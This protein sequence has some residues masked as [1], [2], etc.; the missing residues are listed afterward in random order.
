MKQNLNRGIELGIYRDDL[1]IEFISRIYFTGL[2]GI[3][4]TD[5]FPNNV[6]APKVLTELYLEYHLR[7]IVTPKGL[8]TLNRILAEDKIIF[9]K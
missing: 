1:D 5:I 8:E 6:F 9:K 3:K 7:S 4:D 2:T